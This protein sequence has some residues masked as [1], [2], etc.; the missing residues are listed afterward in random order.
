[1]KIQTCWGNVRSV[2]WLCLLVSLSLAGCG[3][4]EEEQNEE[5][6]VEGAYLQL[7]DFEYQ[8]LPTGERYLTGSLRNRSNRAISN[9]Q[10]QVSLFDSSNRRIGQMSFVV[11]DVSPGGTKRFREPVNA[12][13]EV[14]G[15]RVREILVL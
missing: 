15:A 7:E 8:S 5:G 10:V 13:D 14:M 3:P 12:P 11:K 9:A 1:M 4:L 6:R 2:V